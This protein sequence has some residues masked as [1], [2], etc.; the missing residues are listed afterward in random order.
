MG[1]LAYLAFVSMKNRVRVRIKR[2]REVRYA[3]GMLM[4]LLYF[5]FI[6]GGRHTGSRG[7]H[8]VFAATREQTEM[9]AAVALFLLVCIGWAWPSDGK[10]AL[11]FTRAEVHFLFPAPFSRRQLISYKLLRLQAAGLFSSVIV[12]IFFRPGTIAAGWMFLTGFM[13]VTSILTVHLTAVSLSRASL[14]QHGRR[15]LAHQWLPLGVVVASIAILVTTVVQAWWPIWE[16]PTV[17]LRI[18]ELQRLSTHGLAGIVL[19]P[20]RSVV[21]LPLA[22]TPAE[23]FKA[24]PVPLAL[25]LLSFAW[26]VRSDAAFEEASAELAE[27]VARIRSGT[28]PVVG[29]IKKRKAPFT[30][31]T[32]GRAET[33]LL[34]KNLIMLGRYTTMKRGLTFLPAIVIVSVLM[35]LQA[36]KSGYADAA[37]FL[38]M[39]GA[40]IT[41]FMGPMMIRNDLRRDLESVEMLKSWPLTGV[42]IVRGEILAPTVAL[43]VFAWAF[44]LGTSASVA[45]MLSTLGV[46]VAAG[47]ASWVLAGLL[48]AP[49][50]IATQ[51]LAQNGLAVLFPAWVSIGVT[52]TQGLDV[53]G[54]RMLMFVGI[55]LATLLAL[56]PAVL[57]AALAA[58]VVYYATSIVSIVLPALVITVSLLAECAVATEFLGRVMDRTDPA[59]ID[60][61]E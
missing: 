37:A 54:Q 44:I 45:H 5:Y 32:T 58:G 25:L 57:F 36:R 42:V 47:R 34:W 51:V 35:G 21:Q 4:G 55:L 26:A 16:Q 60:P 38:C 43:T 52:H 24:L 17:G 41:V 3:A 19:W 48:V 22:P 7:I 6:L 28:Q 18:W 46:G 13:L 33:A 50:L 39:L 1:A 30:L 14:I 11:M 53:M 23:F 40:F 9:F 31:A 61:V 15:G 27:K 10:A 8:A 56:L 12:T 59:A 20:F 29:T 2:L 49:A